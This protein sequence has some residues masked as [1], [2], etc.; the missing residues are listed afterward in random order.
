MGLDATLVNFSHFY[1]WNLLLSTLDLTPLGVNFLGKKNLHFI[2]Y[3]ACMQ[4]SPL[5]QQPFY[6]FEEQRQQN[7]FG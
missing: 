6:F 7:F 2:T 1:Q 4:Q 5:R 3:S